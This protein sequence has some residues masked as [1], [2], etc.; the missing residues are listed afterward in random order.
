M[1]G[2]IYTIILTT[3]AIVAAVL[4]LGKCVEKERG[5]R[6]ALFVLSLLTVLCHYSSIIYYQFYLP[7]Y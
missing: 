4:M 7:E 3:A 5:K 2:V 1:G 6:I